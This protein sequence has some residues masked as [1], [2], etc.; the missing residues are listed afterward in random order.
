MQFSPTP[1]QAEKHPR[2]NTS[3][4]YSNKCGAQFISAPLHLITEHCHLMQ[5]L[6]PPKQ[7]PHLLLFV[8]IDGT[9]YFRQ[10]VMLSSP[11]CRFESGCK[12]RSTACG[13]DMQVRSSAGAERL[14]CIIANVIQHTAFFRPNDHQAQRQAYLLLIQARSKTKSTKRHERAI[15]LNMPSESGGN[16]RSALTVRIL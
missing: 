13:W 6:C 10:R 9:S 7:F 3:H 14:K 4:S 5:R 16:A 15:C 1:L 8:H 11:D 12:V 2:R